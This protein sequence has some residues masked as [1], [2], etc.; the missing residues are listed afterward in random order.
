MKI[1]DS[2]IEYISG[3]VNGLVNVANMDSSFIF[4]LKY[5]TKDNF[6]KTEVYPLK[7]CVLQRETALKLISANNEFKKLGYRIKIWDAYRPMYVQKIFWDIVKDEKFV[8]NPKNGSRHNKGT[9]VDI[10]LVDDLGI[11]LKMPSKFDD[12]SDKACRNNE[13]MDEEE[14]KNINLLTE[15]MKRHGFI[16]IDSEW[17][18]FDDINHYKYEITDINLEHF[19]T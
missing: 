16:T 1:I 5:A 9:A 17:W 6:T 10:T 11:E 7:V 3:N 4:D 18:H 19:L 15:V 8:A 13:S 2:E 12:F 14:R